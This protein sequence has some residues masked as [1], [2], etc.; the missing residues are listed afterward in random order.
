M[1]SNYGSVG[2]VRVLADSRTAAE[3]CAERLRSDIEA[4]LGVSLVGITD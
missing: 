3:A 2:F 4:A 1:T